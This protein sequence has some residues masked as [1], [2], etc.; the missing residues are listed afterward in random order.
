[1]GD[2]NFLRWPS[3]RIYSR[4]EEPE[5]KDKEKEQA[6]LLLEWAEHNFMEQVITSPTRKGN[7]LDLVFTNSSNLVNNYTT[8]VNIAFS[9]HNILKLNL[10]YSYKTEKKRKRKTR[11]QTKYMN[12]NFKWGLKKI[13]LDMQL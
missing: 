2:F 4:E 6:K 7:I 3:K 10:N 13:G 8:I 9:D 12:M 11:I 1:M 5:H